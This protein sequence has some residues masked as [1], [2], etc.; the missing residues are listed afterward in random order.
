MFLAD[1]SLAGV[2][3]PRISGR[4]RKAIFI[5]DDIFSKVAAQGMRPTDKGLSQIDHL[6]GRNTPAKVAERLRKCLQSITTPV[7][8]RTLA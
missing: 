1:I 8:I 7:R 4:N 5:G 2:T 6:V 3:R